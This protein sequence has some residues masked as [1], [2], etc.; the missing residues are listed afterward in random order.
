VTL[1]DFYA[2]VKTYFFR[3]FNYAGVFSLALSAYT[4]IQVNYISSEGKSILF[5][6]GLPVWMVTAILLGAVAV[7]LLL[8]GTIEFKKVASQ[9]SDLIWE[10]GKRTKTLIDQIEYIYQQEKKREGLK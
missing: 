4:A 2:K 1:F 5:S 10:K 6:T 8:F 9:E 3:A 7:V